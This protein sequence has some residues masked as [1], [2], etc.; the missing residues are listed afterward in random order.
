MQSKVRTSPKANNTTR[1]AC[2]DC[3][4]L[5]SDF[6]VHKSDRPGGVYYCP[7]CAP[8]HDAPAFRE[9]AEAYASQNCKIT[10][11]PPKYDPEVGARDRF[12]GRWKNPLSP[13]AMLIPAALECTNCRDL[14]RPF[15]FAATARDLAYH[16]AIFRRCQDLIL[17]AEPSLGT[18]ADPGATPESRAR[19]RN[20]PRRDEPR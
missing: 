14:T 3:T 5:A 20:R 10:A 17:E 13:N 4:T 15:K 6:N 1:L 7:Y 11:R 19:A 18:E 12:G 2:A 16:M 9:E 8:P